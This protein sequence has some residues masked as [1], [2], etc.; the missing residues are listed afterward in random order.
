MAFIQD[1][2]RFNKDLHDLAI[3][4]GAPKNQIEYVC[5]EHMRKTFEEIDVY[6]ED[7]KGVSWY[8][9]AGEFYTHLYKNDLLVH[10][11]VY[12]KYT[13]QVTSDWVHKVSSWV[14]T[15]HPQLVLKM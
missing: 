4:Y 8:N 2:K 6:M 14:M 3:A 11:V 7:V 10:F 1:Y 12:L 5:T 15:Q 9:D 13:K